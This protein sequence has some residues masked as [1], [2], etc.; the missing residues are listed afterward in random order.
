MQAQH[1]VMTKTSSL[2]LKASPFTSC[3]TFRLQAPGFQDSAKG[4][5]PSSGAEMNPVMFRWQLP[6]RDLY[7]VQVLS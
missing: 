7:G 5:L 1:S 3:S 2:L 6:G 4:L